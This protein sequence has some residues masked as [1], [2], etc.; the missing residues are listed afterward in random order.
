MA[1]G[2]KISDVA[3]HVVTL[4][5]FLKEAADQTEE[6]PALDFAPARDAAKALYDMLGGGEAEEATDTDPTLAP[7]ER[8]LKN[9]PPNKGEKSFDRTPR[10]SDFA[11]DSIFTSTPPASDRPLRMG[12]MGI[13]TVDDIFGC[14][15]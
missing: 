4:Q 13:Y 10:A 6:T 3:K 15:K 5:N 11:L 2:T 12:D 8:R 7:E 14:G 9:E 1:E